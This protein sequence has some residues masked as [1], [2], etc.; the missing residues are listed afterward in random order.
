MSLGAPRLPPAGPPLPTAAPAFFAPPAARPSPAAAAADDD[1][2]AA[3]KAR[4]DP[5]TGLMPAE[6]WAAQLAAPL[7]LLLVLKADAGAPPEWG[8]GAGCGTETVAVADCLLATVKQLKDTIAAR[9][10]LPANKC[11]LKSTAHGFL[12]DHLTVAHYN[13]KPGEALEVSRK[14]R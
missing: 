7:E 4:V 8:L 6:A 2:P 3:K 14:K 12:K 11:Q 5:A 10:G 13:L 1:G 9:V